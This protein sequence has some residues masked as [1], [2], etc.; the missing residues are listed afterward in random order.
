MLLRCWSLNTPYG[1][2]FTRWVLTMKV[3]QTQLQIARGM[4]SVDQPLQR[5]ADAEG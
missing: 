3:F 2:A 4:E 5:D 1:V